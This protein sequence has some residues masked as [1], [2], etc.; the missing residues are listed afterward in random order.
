M[1]DAGIPSC[2]ILIASDKSSAET[3]SYTMLV[4][5]AI[6]D[7]AQIQV[8]NRDLYWY[9][10]N[11]ETVIRLGMSTIRRERSDLL[12]VIDHPYLP[13]EDNSL[14]DYKFRISGF[15]IAPGKVKCDASTDAG[16]T[17]IPRGPLGR[18]CWQKSNDQWS[19]QCRHVRNLD[20]SILDGC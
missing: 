8:N 15:T 18:K 9:C 20:Q 1:I 13:L 4:R 5:S 10:Y 3:Q 6:I 17:D 7:S 11:L 12:S 14:V 2:S 16:T 19:I